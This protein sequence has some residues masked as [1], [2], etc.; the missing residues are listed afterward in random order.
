MGTSP[1][2]VE[3]VKAQAEVRI[4]CIVRFEKGWGN[5]L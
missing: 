2:T 3:R 4:Q 1:T 5:V